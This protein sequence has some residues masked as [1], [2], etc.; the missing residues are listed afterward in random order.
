V[1]ERWI[2]PEDCY[3]VS[4]SHRIITVPMRLSYA[5]DIWAGRDRATFLEDLKKILMAVDGCGRQRNL[6]GLGTKKDSTRRGG[7][8]LKGSQGR[9]LHHL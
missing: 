6:Q 5:E 3:P 4:T 2:Q 8:H 7:E 1:R 9:H